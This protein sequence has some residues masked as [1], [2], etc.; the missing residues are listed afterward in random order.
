MGTMQ[1]TRGPGRKR[2][3]KQS[4]LSEAVDAGNDRISEL[5]LGGKRSRHV[6]QK[7]TLSCSTLKELFS[8]G[9]F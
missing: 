8:Q 5:Q 1:A 4:A 7:A 6:Y 9:N 2:Q 3:R